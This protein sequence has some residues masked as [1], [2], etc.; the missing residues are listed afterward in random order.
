MTNLEL[1]N[2]GIRP[3]RFYGMDHIPEGFNLVEDDDWTQ[4]YKYQVNA[5]VYEKDGEFF[6]ISNS[7]SG[8]YH[9]DWYYDTAS[10]EQ[11]RKVE[12]VVVSVSWE[13]I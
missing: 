9:T 3:E 4:D 11:V 7:R 8:S 1:L 12:K 10:V 6:R 5:C 2:S 13:P